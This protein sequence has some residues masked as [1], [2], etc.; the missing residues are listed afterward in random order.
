MGFQAKSLFNPDCTVDFDD[1]FGKGDVKMCVR[2]EVGVGGTR[3]G[4]KLCDIKRAMDRSKGVGWSKSLVLNNST[5]LA[6]KVVWDNLN[7]REMTSNDFDLQKL[8]DC[9]SLH[10]ETFNQLYKWTPIINKEFFTDDHNFSIAKSLLKS[11]GEDADY[12]V[13]LNGPPG[14]SERVHHRTYVSPQIHYVDFETGNYNL[15]PE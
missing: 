1:P 11:K 3:S 2:D 10:F 8:M 15:L 13:Q 5:Q 7:I 4:P 6:L 9:N 12:Y 14:Y